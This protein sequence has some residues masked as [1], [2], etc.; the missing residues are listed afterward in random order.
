MKKSGIQGERLIGLF[1]L[2]ILLINP[3]LILI[4]DRPTTFA[5]FPI[6]YL[7]LFVAWA[8]L[9]GLLVVVSEL[10][11]DADLDGDMPEAGA[12]P[13]DYEDLQKGD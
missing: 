12:E 6:L 1:L 13:S 4:F 8:T 5:G 3:P 7:Y 10:A 9:I 11:S 2:A